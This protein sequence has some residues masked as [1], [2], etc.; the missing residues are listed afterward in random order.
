MY[1]YYY[2]YYYYEKTLKKGIDTSVP[3]SWWQFTVSGQILARLEPAGNKTATH[4]SVRL[5]VCL[6]AHWK[7]A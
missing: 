1:Y 7:H 2:Y 6:Y 3:E 5:L 4:V